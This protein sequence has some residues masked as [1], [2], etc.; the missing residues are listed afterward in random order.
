MAEV[1]NNA[2]RGAVLSNKNNSAA[3]QYDLRSWQGLTEVLKR[4]REAGLS[5]AMY[6][7]FR[8]M[9]LSYAQTGG[10]PEMRKKID[11]V[12]SSFASASK[13]APQ[14]VLPPVPKTAPAPDTL[15]IA[16]PISDTPAPELPAKD[17][18][19]EPRRNTFSFI[20]RS[21]GTDESVA[22]VSQM[23][24]TP[25]VKMTS[26]VTGKGD[27]AAQEKVAP[28][29]VAAV[30]ISPLP[31][32][33]VPEPVVVAVPVPTPVP[34]PVVSAPIPEPTPEPFPV[35]EVLPTPAPLPVEP[36]APPTPEPVTLSTAPGELRTLDEHKARIAEIKRT[37]N[38]EIGNPITLVD[39]GNPVGRE[40]MTALLTAMKASGNGGQG[41]DA[42]ME[43]LEG[44]FVRACDASKKMKMADGG[45][46]QTS[47]QPVSAVPE[48]PEPIA[49]PVVAPAVPQQPLPEPEPVPEIV[50]PVFEPV[51]VPVREPVVL[52]PE[53]ETQV[54][55]APIAAPTPTP[56]PTPVVPVPEPVSII[57]EAQDD[58]PETDPLINKY[59]E[60]GVG[61][62]EF[63][64]VSQAMGQVPVEVA[65][66][67][68]DLASTEITTALNQLLH[69]WS[70]FEGSGLFG[71]GP[72]GAE[73]PLY[74]KLA[75]LSMGEVLAGRWERA[76][77]EIRRTLKDYVDAWRHEQGIAYNPTENFEHYLRRVVQRILK[78]QKGEP[79]A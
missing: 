35:V 74:K 28:V 16:T 6:A 72:G 24:P 30:P 65:S 62:V 50:E 3:P 26:L 4:A 58:A 63:D 43:K 34:E 18:I 64:P 31:P 33:P 41:L 59:V 54:E 61:R 8:N 36:I 23:A 21:V 51:P 9:V 47:P 76:T 66:R 27:V 7:E 42:A 68:S 5:D 60:A 79:D 70:M 78:R 25:L 22:P 13:V 46:V 40:Y 52:P 48:A 77:P 39:A 71:I 20:P 57:Q 38:N 55:S 12:V 37:V 45:A 14:N 10:D 32:T 1:T 29:S 56:I 49:E 53:P 15:P 44:A 17:R 75:T 19:T 2:S 67:Q 11:A 73:H 69:E